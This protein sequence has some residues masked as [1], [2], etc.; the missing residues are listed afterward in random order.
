MRHL[1]DDLQNK[2]IP[3]LEAEI[4]LLIGFARTKLEDECPPE[5]LH[6]A[7]QHFDKEMEKSEKRSEL[8]KQKRESGK[9]QKKQKLEV[10]IKQNSKTTSNQD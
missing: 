3:S 6:A 9:V 4:E 8:L 7:R 5:E 1:K 2:V 10:Y